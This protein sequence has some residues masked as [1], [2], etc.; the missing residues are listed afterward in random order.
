MR[1]NLSVLQ[2]AKTVIH[3]IQALLIFIAACISIAVFT[4][5]PGHTD[6]RSKWFFALVSAAVRPTKQPGV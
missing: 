4:G 1:Q 6:G 5:G 2:K 3:V